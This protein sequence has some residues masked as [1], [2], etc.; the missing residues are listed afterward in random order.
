MASSYLNIA[1]GKLYPIDFEEGKNNFLIQ[2]DKM[3]F[4]GGSPQMVEVDHRIWLEK[5][6]GSIC[7]TSSDVFEFLANYKYQFDNISLYRFLEHVTK[8]DIQG[9]IYLLST[10][11]KIGGIV[12]VIVP[13]F[14]TLANMILGENLTDKVRHADWERHD[15]TL[16]YEL[17]NE[18]SMPHAS[19][20]TPAR[21]KYFF[22][23]EERFEFHFMN[24]KYEFDGRDLYIR[25]KFKRV[26]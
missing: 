8:P 17:L 26:R 18:P 10:A 14:E 9:F 16:T 15:T 11:I 5:Q 19:I 23:L 21:L 24:E 13:N 2:L 12:D 20:W 7:W 4:S 6:Q 3:Y 1:A 25:I 22:E